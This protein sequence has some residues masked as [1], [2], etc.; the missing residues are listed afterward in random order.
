MFV[1]SFADISSNNP[2]FDAGA[3]RRGGAS[4]ICVKATQG[5]TYVNPYH[6]LWADQAHAQNLAVGH[7]HYATP[8]PAGTVLA[9]VMCFWGQVVD[10][11]RQHDFLI[12]D[13]ERGQAWLPGEAQRFAPAFAKRL[14]EES[15]HSLVGYSER[16]FL[17]ECGKA[18][19][20]PG[21]RWWEAD[22]S[23]DQLPVAWR[24]STWAWQHTDGVN[25]PPPH[26]M[27]GVGRCDVSTLNLASY[28]RLRAQL[29]S[30]R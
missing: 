27:P 28:L 25:G 18:I 9:Q 8:G 12:L 11:W 13:I 10:C 1:R 29:A 20:I 6:R 23:E 16:S 5:S 22:Y 15:G 30:H 24:R 17:N 4:L 19:D 14:K 7:Y 21:S 26:S 3:Y 2:G